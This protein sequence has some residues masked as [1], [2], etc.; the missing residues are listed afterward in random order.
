MALSGNDA[1][2]S[3]GFFAD[4]L[5]ALAELEKWYV[6]MQKTFS[7]AALWTGFVFLLGVFLCVGWL[8]VVF[9]GVGLDD[10]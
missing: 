3:Y 2:L 5:E 9:L 8:V 7:L 10:L 1:S 4:M 6:V